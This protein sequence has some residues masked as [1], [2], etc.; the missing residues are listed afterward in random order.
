MADHKAMLFEQVQVL[1]GLISETDRIYALMTSKLKRISPILKKQSFNSDDQ[2]LLQDYLHQIHLDLNEFTQMLRRGQGER[3]LVH[4]EV[5]R[6]KADRSLK[7]DFSVLEIELAT[8]EKNLSIR[9]KGLR[10]LSELVQ[11]LDSIS[12]AGE[13]TEF[14]ERL[15]T[16][17]VMDLK[18]LAD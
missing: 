15:L 17:I 6:M 18:S 14:D 7:E 10:H 13:M 3:D 1:G 12:Q 16:E 8:C 5:L 11:L 9:E 2:D 4:G